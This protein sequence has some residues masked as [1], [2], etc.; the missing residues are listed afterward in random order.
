MKCGTIVCTVRELEAGRPPSQVNVFAYIFVSG[1]GEERGRERG[2]REG[3]MEGDRDEGVR[4]RG[5]E[6]RREL[7]REVGGESCAASFRAESIHHCQR[8]V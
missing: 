7:E 2:K 3:G 6:K 8:R 5:G 1:F 4:E